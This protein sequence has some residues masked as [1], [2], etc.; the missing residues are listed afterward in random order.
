MAAV[1]DNIAIIGLGLIGGS[2]ARALHAQGARVLAYDSDP[3]ALAAAR[4]QGCV[5][6]ALSSPQ[7]EPNA[8]GIIAL[9]VPPGQAPGIMAAQRQAMAAGALLTDVCSSKQMLVDSAV[10]LLPAELLPRL[11]PGHPL[12]GTERQGFGAS[13]ASLFES[14]RVILTPLE[15]SADGAVEAIKALWHA[16]GASRVDC[17]PAARH[18][19]LLSAASHLP[20]MLAYSLMAY[21]AASEDAAGIMENS[22]GGLRDFTRI[23]ESSPELWA[24][25]ALANGRFVAKDLAGCADAMNALAAAISSG[26][27]DSLLRLLR[28][29]RDLKLAE[30]DDDRG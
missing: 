30:K 20:H 12:A 4:E 3:K 24:D 1:P 7:L 9:C 29:A 22:A 27:R 16:C 28:S 19:S 15:Q 21:I 14:C 18:D 17:M 6:V 23:A 2:M 8:A 25:I 5:D 26:D 10:S 11:V 13:T